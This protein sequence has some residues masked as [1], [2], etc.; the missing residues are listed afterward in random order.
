MRLPTALAALLVLL[1]APLVG[2]AQPSAEDRTQGRVP[3]ETPNLRGSIRLAGAR[4]DDL[5]LVRYRETADPASAMVRLLAPADSALPRFA[6]FG[7]VGRTDAPVKLP[8]ADAVWKQE[9]TGPLAPGKPV[10]LV[11]DNGEGLAF[12]RTFAVDERFLFT[13]KDEVRNAG[14]APVTLYPYGRVVRQGTPTVLNLYTLHEGPIALIGDAGLQ[15]TT[16]RDLAEKKTIDWRASNAWLG[17]TDRYWATILLPPQ[18]EALHASFSGRKAGERDTYQG[19]Y[20]LEARTVAS[21]AGATVEVH[22]FAGAKEI[23]VI[24]AY[25]EALGLRSFDLLVDWGWF[26]FVTRPLMLTLMFFAG[27]A[28]SYG[29]AILLLAVAIRLAFLPLAHA[30]YAATARRR[31]GQVEGQKA[32]RRAFIATQLVVQFALYKMLMVAVEFRHAPF[33]GWVHDLSA[34]DRTNVF[35]LFG[36]IPFDPTTLPVFGPVLDL[37]AWAAL[38]CVVTWILVRLAPEPADPTY[39]VLY[40]ATPLVVAYTFTNFPVGT[41]IFWVWNGVLAI[42]HQVAVARRHGAASMFIER[43]PV[44]RSPIMRA[45]RVRDERGRTGAQTM[46]AIRNVSRM[47]FWASAVLLLICLGRP[48]E[49]SSGWFAAAGLLAIV[50]YLVA[51]RMG[52]KLAGRE[53]AGELAK[54]AE[55]DRPIVLFLRSF[56]IAKSSLLTRV[57]AELGYVAK[58]SFNGSVAAVAGD[59]GGFADRRYDVEE[60]LDD[61]IGNSAMFVAIGDRLASYGAAKIKVSDAEWQATFA[62][63]AKAAQAIFIMPGPS[64]AL[65][66]EMQQIAGSREL[67]RKAIFIMPRERSRR[68]VAKIW[69]QAS[70]MAQRVGYRLPPYSAEGCYFRIGDDGEVAATMGL[71][72]LTRALRACLKDPASKGVIDIETLWGRGAATVTVA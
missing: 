20:V 49:E 43:P 51:L 26:S 36:L 46:R 48:G 59:A 22:L 15:E 21:G 17:F 45:A 9:G 37:G 18:R 33:V 10:T 52:Q 44:F 71:E 24:D 39:K 13:I 42:A 54:P 57:W 38:M 40:N 72:P 11:W 67:L 62:H 2:H 58:A 16:Y 14:S 47:V 41:V 12:R 65:M 19:D 70:D 56:G 25:G 64:E 66:W 53:F 27:L 35:N 32:L 5:V 60:N 69:Q 8:N 55:R 30:A 6:S 23:A 63:L 34:P 28:G 50:T 1:L 3:I 7:W 31:T 29:A 61:A 68:R 4:I